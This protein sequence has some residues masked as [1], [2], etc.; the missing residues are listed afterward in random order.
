MMGRIH[1]LA[2]A[3]V[4]NFYWPQHPRII[5]LRLADAT[6]DLAKDGAERL[7][8]AEASG[9]WREVAGARDLDIVDVVV[10]NALHR[11]VVIEALSRG[12]HVFCEKPLS[13]D[14]SEAREMYVAAR[15][16][17]VAHQT[18]FV[19]RLFPAIALAKK[20][21]SDGQI[22]EVRYFRG[23]WLSDW[24][25]DPLAPHSWRFERKHAGAG[26]LADT[27]SHVI[28]LARYLIG[29]EVSRVLARFK[30]YITHRPIP[31]GLPGHGITERPVS[32]VEAKLGVVDTDD[33]TDLMLE[34][35][36]GV[37]GTICLART[38]PGHNT[39]MAFEVVGSRGSVSFS[40][41]Y[42]NELRYFSMDDPESSRGPRT[43]LIGKTHP[44]AEPFWGRG[45]AIGYTDAFL[46][47]AHQF[48]NYISDG[49]PG[50]V[51][52]FL[53]GLRV[54]EVIDA[55]ITSGD[56]GKW[57]DVNHFDYS[58]AAV[59]SPAR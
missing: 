29:G 46:I 1:S 39:D 48:L 37:V 20:I 9:D 10:P 51:A 43:I 17:R 41:I 35:D 56:S 28:D 18:G 40:W 38:Y 59:S 34:F 4:C 50:Q 31:P 55:A 57:V 25:T 23:Q 5:K 13:T 19:Y 8:W 7:G 53:D 6:L 22:G 47:Q 16:A 21:I 33:L 26:V 3:N 36:S 42:G 32:A 12:K 49:Q 24:A 27:G 30:T 15:N 14:L 58:P 2:W 52:T 11:D 54:G 45:I 44:N